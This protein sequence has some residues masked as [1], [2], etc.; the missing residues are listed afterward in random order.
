MMSNTTNNN[1]SY[2]YSVISVM[3]CTTPIDELCCNRFGTMIHA[4]E[5]A[6]VPH[7]LKTNN[8]YFLATGLSIRLCK[9]K[10]VTPIF[11][12]IDPVRL[13]AAPLVQFVCLCLAFQKTTFQHA[14]T[15]F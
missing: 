5:S 12:G 4:S 9:D 14:G 15:T 10:Q 1:Y 7:Q 8:W 6:N 2:K 3:S 11:S 13:A